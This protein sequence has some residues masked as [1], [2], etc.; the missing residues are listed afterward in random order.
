MAFSFWL[1]AIFAKESDGLA[2]GHIEHVVDI[3]VLV[4]DVEDVMLE[5]VTVTG[6]TLEDEVG[7]KL[8]LDG[9]D[10]SALTL[11]ATSTVGIE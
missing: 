2:D 4:A 9:D 10:T 6:F 8:H 3:L 5:A 1:L 11:V 7:H